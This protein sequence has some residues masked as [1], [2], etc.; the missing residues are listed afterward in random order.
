MG[1]RRIA[2]GGGSRVLR[3]RGGRSLAGSRIDVQLPALVG[4]ERCNR[5]QE[6]QI[7]KFLHP[8]NTTFVISKVC[9]HSLTLCR[10]RM[11]MLCSLGHP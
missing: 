11:W 8:C 5:R 3:R 9:S 6:C 1:G 2:S 10:P 7:P 4:G